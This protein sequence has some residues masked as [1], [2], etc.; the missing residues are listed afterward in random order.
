M[1][2]EVNLSA[3]ELALVAELNLEMARAFDEVAEDAIQR[4]ETRRAARELASRR[5]ERARLCHLEARRLGAEPTFPDEQLTAEASLS[6][7]GPERRKQERRRRERRAG[8][9]LP[10]QARRRTEVGHDRRTN[11]DRRRGERR[12]HPPGQSEFS[13]A[14]PSG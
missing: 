14:S 2:A 8:R 11:P 10:S 13:P 9:S 5:R 6:Y 7:T 12:R 4:L 1:V 3:I